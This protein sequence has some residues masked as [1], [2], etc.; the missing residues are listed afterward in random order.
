M[1]ERSTRALQVNTWVGRTAPLHLTSASRALTFDMDDHDVEALLAVTPF[2]Q[3][4]PNSPL[5]PS[6]VIE[7]LARERRNGFTL[8]IDEL[9]EDLIAVGAPIWDA[10]GRIVAAVNVSGPKSRMRDEFEST[11]QYVKAAAVRISTDLGLPQRWVDPQTH[12]LQGLA[13]S[14][15]G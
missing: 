13:H 7:R 12:S 11:G 14:Y 15:D 1:S 8:A 6:D 2:P 3:L 10:S 5:H 4:G 9:E